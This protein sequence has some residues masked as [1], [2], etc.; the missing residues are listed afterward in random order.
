VRKPSNNNHPSTQLPS[1]PEPVLD[2]IKKTNMQRRSFIK[3]FGA[4]SALLLPMTAMLANRAKGA[5]TDASGPISK[6]DAAILTFLGAAEILES[7][8]WLQY[9][10]L[11]GTQDNEFAKMTGGNPFYTDA[12]TILDGDMAQYIHDNTDDEITHASFIRDYLASR[13][14]STADL[15]LLNGHKFRTVPGSS[16]QG[17]SGKLR[18]TNLTQLNVDTSFWTRYR[19]DS[20]NPDLSGFNF[21]Q[22]QNRPKGIRNRTAIP[23]NDADTAG[24]SIGSPTTHLK[25]IAFTAGFHFAKIEQGGTSLYP[26]LAQRVSDKEVL[27]VVLSIGPTEAMHFQTWQDKAGNAT[28]LTDTDPVTGSVVTFVDLTTGQPQSLQSNLIMPEPCPFLRA[29]LPICSIVRPTETTGAATGALKFLTAMGLF[30]GQ[31]PAFFELLGQLASE[32]DAA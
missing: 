18:L 21:G 20:Q 14:A 26:S 31:T 13:G 6:G 29:S 23:R 3:G 2:Q 17:S 11:G 24:S 22:A 27:R 12:L 32:A 10:E 8:L 7:D 16:A 1:S 15:D 4:T 25:A 30:V 19:S 28:P 5:T 9:W